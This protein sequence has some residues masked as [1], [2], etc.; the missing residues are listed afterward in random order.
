MNSTIH[1]HS[2]TTT[3]S[4]HPSSLF[5]QIS[6]C[7][8]IKHLKQIH[9]HFIKTAL[10]SD[11]LAAA[12]F[13]KSLSLSNHR[14]L[15][16]AR[17]FFNQVHQPNC[18][19]W[20]TI[21]RA[22][23]E[24]DDSNEHPLESLLLFSRMCSDG[25]VEPNRFTFPSVLKACAR[26]ARL[27]E[28]RQ[29]HGFVVKLGFDSD[30][31]VASNLV[32]LYVMC[33][34]MDD[35]SVLFR[36]HV[37]QYDDCG[38]LVRNTRMRD[39]IVVLWNVMIDGCVRIKDLIASRNLF[40]EMPH[41]SVVSWNV[42]ISGYAQNGYFKEAVEMFRDMQMGDISP[43]YVTLVS[44]LPAISR[45]G[46]LELGKW[47]HLYAE[48]NEIEIND[49]LGSALI[50]MYS[51]C[52]SIEKAI[53]VFE[54]VRNKNNVIVW[55]AIIGGLALHGR[56]KCALAY[57]RMMQEAGLAPSD[58]VYIGLL[59]A[60]SHA[61][62]VEEGRLLFNHMI[63]VDGLEPRIEHYGCMVDLLGRAGL[64]EEAEQVIRKM[65]IKP[66]DVI[67]KALLSACKMHGNIEMGERIARI[68]MELF[69]EDSGSYVALSNMFACR[70]NWDGVSEVRLKMKELEIRKDPGCSWIELNGEIHEF[71][72]ED[73]S[74]PRA[75]E[76]RSML[77]EISSR[78]RSIGYQ[79]D[80]TQVT[81]NIDEED[82]ENALNY[83]SEKIA[84][85]FGLISSS[86]QSPLKI[87]KNLRICED[88]HSSIKLIS[89]IYKRK[90]IVRDRKRFHHF[91]NGSC[92]CMDYW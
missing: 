12:E 57:Y 31:F 65:P 26:T 35:A 8:S 61:G 4:T 43:N 13:L 51:K 21:I 16:Y 37:V 9:A 40:D 52:G 66:D 75:Q 42:M 24:S 76:I 90:I 85:A 62:L 6:S 32:R 10:I 53:Q 79:P 45:L 74:N 70:G 44:V 22:F 18:F 49:V 81:V 63:N 64:L 86:P 59:N 28:G 27:R 88:C 11:P 23:A 69:P 56:A 82:K 78:L 55:S 71:L 73:G 67:W 25:N 17:K 29:V 15:S 77:E 39:G 54:S 80:T 91:E 34:V 30:E 89:K 68:L 38:K 20:N 14:D 84:I 5:P 92:S 87:V 7:K 47:V 60:C 83:H 41:R 19:S 2:I 50:D 58:V 1:N 33:G 3:P 46:A 72:V 36:K 48:K